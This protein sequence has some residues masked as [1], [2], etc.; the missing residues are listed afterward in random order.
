[1]P[2]F[3]STQPPR[4]NRTLQFAL[5]GTSLLWV[6]AADAL[7]ASAARGL[8]VRFNLPAEATLLKS[9]LFLFLLVLGFAILQTISGHP[10]PLREIIGLP[11]R[12]TAREE[13]T[14]GAALGWGTIVLAVLP[15][16]IFGRLH[17]HFFTDAR[18]VLLVIINLLTLLVAALAEEV[19]FRGFP[20]RRLIQATGPVTATIIMAILF[21]LVHIANPNATGIGLLIAMLAGVVLSIAWLR[22]HGLWLPWGLHFAWN[23]SMGILFGLPVSGLTDFSS[24]IQTDAYGRRWLTG[25]DYGPEAAFFTIFACLASLIVLVFLTREYAWNYTHPPIVA[26]GYALDVAPPPA[27]AAMEQEAQSR[28]G[29]LVQILPTTPSTM[30]VEP[31]QQPVAADTEAPPSPS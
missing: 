1:L 15:M 20:F 3:Q 7:A 21:G 4:L 27:H 19:A 14:L 2:A 9:F 22:T 28:P 26:G 8:W 12:P 30:S 31:L 24:V 17:V 16:A 18:S 13:W 10:R 6:F 11:Q 5:F 29:S 23:A 25:G